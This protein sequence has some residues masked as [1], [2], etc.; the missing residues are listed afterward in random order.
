[1]SHLGFDG[2]VVNLSGAHVLQL[3]GM[4]KCLLSRF[5]WGDD[6]G[7]VHV[8][9]IDPVIHLTAIKL[10]EDMLSELVVASEVPC[11]MASEYFVELRIHGHLVLGELLSELV[12][13]NGPCGKALDG[14][15]HLLL[16]SI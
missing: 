8:D 10:S 14:V 6:F 13:V 9:L 11:I 15:T 5:L 1:M 2:E 12:G 7:V 4:S 3:I 16:E